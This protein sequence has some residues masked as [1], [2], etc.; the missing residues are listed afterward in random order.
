VVRA[1]A[2][3]PVGRWPVRAVGQAA[4][5]QLVAT[6]LGHRGR[7]YLRTCARWCACD[8]PWSPGTYL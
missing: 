3:W 7:T 4:G 2:R 1:S 8:V 5:G 6:Y